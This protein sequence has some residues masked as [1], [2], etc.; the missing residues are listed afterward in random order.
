MCVSKNTWAC[1]CHIQALVVDYFDNGSQTL[2]SK[3]RG[4]HS[5]QR[6]IAEKEGAV[7][8]FCELCC[9][10]NGKGT[11]SYTNGDAAG[12]RGGHWCE[13]VS[14]KAAG[15]R[16]EASQT[17]WKAARMSVGRVRLLCVECSSH[18]FPGVYIVDSAKTKGVHWPTGAT[19]LGGKGVSSRSH[20]TDLP[21]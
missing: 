17:R 12:V 16:T 14:A 7:V 18:Y 10:S 4:R 21:L 1:K 5:S 3:F 15:G 2:L 19:Y 8:G 13:D 9:F 6:A 20:T 11:H